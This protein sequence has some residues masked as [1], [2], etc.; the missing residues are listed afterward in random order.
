MEAG[1]TAAE[2]NSF[3]SSGSWGKAALTDYVRRWRHVKPRSLAFAGDELR[4]TWEEYDE[5]STQLAQRL[6]GLGLARGDRMAVL[7]PDGPEV[8]VAWLAAEKAGLVSVGIGARAG[9]REIEHLM[10]TSGAVALLS[11]SFAHRSV[12]AVLERL[13]ARG[14]PVVHV[15]MSALD[16][17]RAWLPGS[18]DPSPVQLA[19]DN[20]AG[21]EER[22]LG[23]SELFMLNSTSGTTGMPKCVT[24]TQNRWYY[25]HQLAVEAG[26][27][28][29]EDV[30]YSALPS[31]FGFGLWTAHC[32]PTFLGSTTH[33]RRE[34]HADEVLAVLSEQQ[35][36]VLAAVST[37]L[38]LLLKAAGSRRPDLGSLRVVFTGGEAVPYEQAMAFEDLTGASVLQFYG[39]NETGALSRTKV[40]DDRA[41]RLKT[42]GRII[43]DM[44]VRLVEPG[45]GRPATGSRGQPACRG[46]ATSEGY[47]NDPEGNAALYTDDGWM[48]MGDVVELDG[49]GYLTVVGRTADIIIRGGKNISAAVVETEVMTHDAVALAAAVAAPDPVFGERICVYVEPQP[50]RRVTLSDI[51]SHLTERGVGK[52]Y[53]PEYL[54]ILEALPRSS[55][56]KVAKAQLREDIQRR[57][58]SL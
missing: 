56:G 54:I 47:Y 15:I 3:V 51:T 35:V 7:F 33:V 28:T 19:S 27:L 41:R 4:I 11:G 32:T 13:R 14:H 6:V 12:E 52:E 39:S 45:T 37:Q 29:E 20:A 17:V 57:V 48:L 16:P 10:V 36:T 43:E 53:L 55:G 44:H 30:F 22:R 21:I 50:G 42:A 1:H 2:I 9:E 26:D 23:P 40:S 49:D 5:L 25:F 38:I 46:P 58:A 34:F 18:V 24:H 31:P 8:H